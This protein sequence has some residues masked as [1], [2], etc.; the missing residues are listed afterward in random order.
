MLLVPSPCKQCRS[1]NSDCKKEYLTGCDKVAWVNVYTYSFV[2]TTGAYAAPGSLSQARGTRRLDGWA[3]AR[4]FLPRLFSP[5]LKSMKLS[6]SAGYTSHS[7]HMWPQARKI[8]VTVSA[9]PQ[10][11]PRPDMC[12]DGAQTDGS[13]SDEPEGRH[14]AVFVSVADASSVRRHSD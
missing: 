4:K 5:T 2:I 13:N 6:K 14:V 3:T 9:S 12:P 7:K 10:K 8:R 11:D 1:S